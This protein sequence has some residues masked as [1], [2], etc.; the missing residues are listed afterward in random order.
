MQRRPAKPACALEAKRRVRAEIG[1]SVVD[2]AEP[3]TQER[4]TAEMESPHTYTG[5]DIATVRPPACP[6]VA[7]GAL[8]A[9]N[10]LDRL[11]TISH[12]AASTCLGHQAATADRGE[13]RACD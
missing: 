10:L 3:R 12:V 1:D 5:K 7:L 8:R 2:A 11:R 9:A 4:R 13:H 6:A